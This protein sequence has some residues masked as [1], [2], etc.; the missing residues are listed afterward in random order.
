MIQKN[1]KFIVRIRES[2]YLKR[3]DFFLGKPKICVK[4]YQDCPMYNNFEREH[5]D[6]LPKIVYGKFLTEMIPFYLLISNITEG[7]GGWG[8]RN[9][10][11][12]SENRNFSGTEPPLD[13]RPVCKFKFVHCGPV[14]NKHDTVE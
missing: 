8:G 9:Y 6:M 7:G 12:L 10:H 4:W 13:L 14:E 1:W 11:P 2:F 5:L 3:L